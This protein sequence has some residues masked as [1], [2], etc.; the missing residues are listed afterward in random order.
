MKLKTKPL[1][2]LSA[3]DAPRNVAK[4]WQRAEEHIIALCRLLIQR[5]AEEQELR[6]ALGDDYRDYIFEAEKTAKTQDRDD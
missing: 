2:K 6:G 5:G 4:H 1:P 3:Y